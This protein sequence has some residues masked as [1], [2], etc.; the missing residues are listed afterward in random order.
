MYGSSAM[1]FEKFGNFVTLICLYALF[2]IFVKCLLFCEVGCKV[3]F[4]LMLLVKE[5]GFVWSVLTDVLVY[6]LKNVRSNKIT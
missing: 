1:G 2:S 4:H 3:H 6:A 5:R